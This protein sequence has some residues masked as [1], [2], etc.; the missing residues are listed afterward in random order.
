MKAE[1]TQSSNVKD[2]H[3]NIYQ[4]EIT[5]EQWFKEKAEALNK[6]KSSAQRNHHIRKHYTESLDQEI[7]INESKSMSIMSLSMSF[8]VENLTDE[9]SALQTLKRTLNSLKCEL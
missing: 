4:S 1:R 6:W 5:D 7:K 2:I 9:V 3:R 8:S